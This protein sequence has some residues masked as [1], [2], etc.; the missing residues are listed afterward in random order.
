MYLLL[1]LGSTPSVGDTS[2]FPHPFLN[3]YKIDVS[4]ILRESDEYAKY[5][6]FQRL[7]TGG[8]PLSPQEVRNAILV[9]VNRGFYSVWVEFR[10]G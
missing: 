1:G 2:L 8:T 9:M 6:L 3:L 7:N 4:I 5:E 10:L